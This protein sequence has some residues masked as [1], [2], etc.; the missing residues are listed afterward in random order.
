MILQ[1]HSWASQQPGGYGI[2]AGHFI[3]YCLHGTA[4]GLDVAEDHQSRYFPILNL[5]PVGN[6]LSS[7][8][9]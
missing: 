9:G 7:A 1:S 8:Q 4:E 2:Q 6:Q 3:G 5:P